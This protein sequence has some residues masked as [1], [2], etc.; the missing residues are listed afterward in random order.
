MQFIEKINF[1]QGI[2]NITFSYSIIGC[3]YVIFTFG[4]SVIGFE[5]VKIKL[6]NVAI[7]FLFIASIYY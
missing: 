1:G 3:V 4:Y 6:N 5:Y 2:V 7:S